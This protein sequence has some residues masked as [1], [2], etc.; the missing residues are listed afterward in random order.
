MKL[1]MK[2]PKKSVSRKESIKL[3][4]ANHILASSE[5]VNSLA[6]AGRLHYLEDSVRN[7]VWHA[8]I[9]ELAEEY[10]ISNK[11]P[12]RRRIAK[13]IKDQLTILFRGD[14]DDKIVV[15]W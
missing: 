6:V 3:F 14:Y 2:L 11:V 9:A 5:I 10:L 15:K 13:V 1:P 4:T 12:R 7:L 8:V